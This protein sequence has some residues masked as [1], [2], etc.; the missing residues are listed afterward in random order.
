MVS[1]ISYI[2][3]S[4]EILITAQI[5]LASW[6]TRRIASAWAAKTDR[7]NIPL[8]M[9]IERDLHFTPMRL[10]EVKKLHAERPPGQVP[11]IIVFFIEDTQE[12]GGSN[13]QQK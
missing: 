1:R 12:E 11:T 7:G 9:G 5:P 8:G 13:D 2:E 6:H 3:T 4:G 10:S